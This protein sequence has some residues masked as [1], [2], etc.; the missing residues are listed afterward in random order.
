MRGYVFDPARLARS[1]KRLED[2]G[3][4]MAARLLR[5]YLGGDPLAEARRRAR[6]DPA[7]RAMFAAAAEQLADA[8]RA[9][10]AETSQARGDA[11]GGRHAMRTLARRL[12]RAERTAEETMLQPMRERVHRIMQ[13]LGGI[14][15]RRRRWRSSSSA[16]PG[17]S[18]GC[19]RGGERRIAELRAEGLTDDRDP[20]RGGRGDRREGRRG[21]RGAEGRGRADRL[22]ADGLQLHGRS[23]ILRDSEPS[24]LS[25]SPAVHA[26]P[27][28]RRSA[29]RPARSSGAGPGHGPCT[30]LGRAASRGCTRPSPAIGSRPGR[31]AGGRAS[32]GCGRCG[33]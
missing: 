30:G 17:R 9:V 26:P 27:V 8:A 19:A 15:A 14:A 16:T 32:G 33:S 22:K 25:G 29:A 31:R 20:R 11:R 4:A 7:L 1:P 18:G 12:D 13:R 10:D 28:R 6:R 5:D 21:F 3:Y 2:D 23:G 24:Q